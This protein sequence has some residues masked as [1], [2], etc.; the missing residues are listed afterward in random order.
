MGMSRLLCE[1]DDS[2]QT[3]LDDHEGICEKFDASPTNKMSRPL[4]IM[5]WNADG[6]NLKIDKLRE[7]FRKEKIDVVLVQKTKLLPPT[8]LRPSP[9]PQ[10]KGFTPIRV[11]MPNATHAGGPTSGRRYVLSQMATV[12]GVQWRLSR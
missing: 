9:T 8:E 2:Q 4:H 7:F 11:D 5:Q 10:I 3:H 6:L 12:R 1:Y